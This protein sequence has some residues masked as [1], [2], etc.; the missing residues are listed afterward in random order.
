MLG[1][2][3]KKLLNPEYDLSG[4]VIRKGCRQCCRILPIDEFYKA[5]KGSYRHHICK[6]CWSEVGQVKYG[7]EK[8][9]RRDPAFRA[10]YVIRDAIRMDRGSGIPVDLTLDWVQM[11]LAKGCSY[12]GGTDIKMTLDRIDNSK[13]HHKDNVV[14]ACIRC[15]FIRKTM[16][17]Q[18]WLCLVPGLKEAQRRGLFED[19]TG[20]FSGSGRRRVNLP[21]P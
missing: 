21:I 19:W 13:G 17:Y 18:A 3:R 20:V 1:S 5:G 9:E 10:K 4:Q 15:N 11:E 14:P 2:C 8:N 7:Q 6:S 12:C 16:P